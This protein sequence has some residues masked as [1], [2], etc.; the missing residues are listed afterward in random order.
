MKRILIFLLIAVAA[1]ASWY[2]WK[3]ML[4]QQQMAAPAM[5]APAGQAAPV[6][7]IQLESRTVELTE[8]LPGRVTAFRHAE[9]RPQV[10]GIITKRLFEE[11]SDVKQGQQ[12]YQIDEAPYAAQHAST[13]ADLKS[14]QA[15]AASIKG[16]VSR[17]ENLVKHNA[18]SRQEY[19]DALAEMDKA[20]A[21]IAVAQAQVDIAQLKLD[22]TR[23]YAPI[24][25]RIGKSSITEG[26]LVTSNQTQSMA[27]I[28]QADPVYVDMAQ[29][30]NEALR[31]RARVA[32]IDEVPVEVI[33]DE[34]SNTRHP[35]PGAL[36]FYAVTVDQTTDSI[37][38]R[39]V[40]P[41]PD[42]QLL[43]GLFIHAEL[44]L[45]KQDVLLVPQRATIRNSEGGVGVWMVDAQSKAELRPITVSSTWQD[46]WVVED[47]L[48]PGDTV[49]ME[50]YQKI[51]AG[52]EVS[53]S[54]WKS[55]ETETAQQ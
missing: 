14:A 47:G 27:T 15:S 25:G 32:A 8:T 23:V 3:V 36:R 43:P 1:A 40:V 21:A 42:G 35:Y 11:G 50:G 2:Y 29:P 34:T 18:I 10:D 45:G 46:Q 48:E 49:I 53:P 9:I 5:Q 33:L 12:L 51:G 31:L 4:P 13:M 41:N 30:A 39:A 19:D 6:S 37:G 54:P 7:V 55:G 52:M 20:N 24:S 22:Y 38:L 16:R 44:D 17:Y 28:T 26:S